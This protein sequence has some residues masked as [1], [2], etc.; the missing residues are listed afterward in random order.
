MRSPRPSCAGAESKCYPKPRNLV[1]PA[2]SRH[3]SLEPG[4]EPALCFPCSLDRLLVELVHSRVD[5][6][7]SA[8]ELPLGLRLRLF[9]LLPGLSAVLIQLLLGLLCLSPGLVGLWISVLSPI[10]AR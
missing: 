8:V 4:T 5:L 7:A 3:R 2:P 6:P 9:V 10:F 1:A